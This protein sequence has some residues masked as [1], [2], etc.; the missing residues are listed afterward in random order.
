MTDVRVRDGWADRIVGSVTAPAGPGP[1]LIGIGG[2]HG[3]EPA[4]LR[5]L[6]AVLAELR[7][8]GRGLVGGRF[9]ALAGNRPALRAGVRYVDRDLNRIWA[10]GDELDD[11]E[12]RERGELLSFLEGFRRESPASTLLVDLHTTSGSAPPFVVVGD[13]CASRELALALPA[14]LVLALSTEIRGTLVE[15]LAREGW[16][17]VGFESGSH[18]GVESVALSTAALWLLLGASG[19]LARG[20]RRVAEA[21]RHLKAA[22]EGLPRAVE[23]FHHH[24][25]SGETEFRMYPGYRSFQPVEEGE[26]LATEGSDEVRAPA[27]GRLLMP[28]YQRTGG[29]GFF[30]ARVVPLASGRG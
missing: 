4:G 21:R 25:V 12:G 10:E 7:E 23:V 29:E 20:D 8:P 1:T 16:T 30:L 13:G 19:L 15:Y 2:I 24:P 9:I 28:L 6:E 14:P 11:V 26:L 17:S 22:A 18:H 5:A 27:S 3:N